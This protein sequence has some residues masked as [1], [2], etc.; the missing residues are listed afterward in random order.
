M[1]RPDLF[2]HPKFLRLSMALGSRMAAAGALECVW[3]MGYESGDPFVGEAAV[4]EYAC[5]WKGEAGMLARELVQAGF[6]EETAEGLEIHDLYD[7]APDYV[8]KRKAR[9]D[10]RAAARRTESTERR[11]VTGQGTDDDRTVTRTPS[12]SPS[13]LPTPK[14]N[15]PVAPPAG[16]AVDEFEEFWRPYP[17]KAKR[18]AARRAWEKLSGADRDAARDGSLVLA[19]VWR[20]ASAAELVYCPHPASWLNG[21]GWEDGRDEA[22]RLRQRGGG[23]PLRGPV[24][25]EARRRAALVGAHRDVRPET[26]LRDV[27][28]ESP[29]W[30]I[31]VARA[32]AHPARPVVSDELYA[33]WSRWRQGKDEPEP[34]GWKAELEAAIAEAVAYDARVS[35]KGAKKC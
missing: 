12:P 5:E 10:E 13:P 7:H 15:P 3:R 33:A 17:R 27:T 2:T 28:Q 1:A 21:R 32:N 22:E 25:L 4:V 23:R 8:R 31:G 24:D 18:P 6:L 30:V 14:E 9:Q 29:A 35:G 11:T 26:P 19:D 20:G 16:G 34:A